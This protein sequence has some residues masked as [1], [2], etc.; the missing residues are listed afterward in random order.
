MFAIDGTEEAIEFLRDPVLCS[1]LVTIAQAVAEQLRK[2]KALRGLMGSDIDAKKV[3]S[4]LTLFGR[5]AKKLD[6]ADGSDAYKS[7][8]AVAEEV[9]S[10]AA[11]QGYPACAYTLS[12][13]RGM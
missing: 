3:V 11:P 9:L 12:R 8:A 6:E 7:L 1:R 13:I 5:V 2:G 10:L 4:S